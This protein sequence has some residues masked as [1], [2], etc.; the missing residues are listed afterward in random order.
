VCSFGFA[1]VICT[2]EAKGFAKHSTRSPIYGETI[3]HYTH[4]IY[5]LDFFGRRHAGGQLYFVGFG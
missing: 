1:Y 5:P 3:A 2:W 4:A